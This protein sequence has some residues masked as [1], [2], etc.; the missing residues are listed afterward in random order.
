MLVAE[1]RASGPLVLVREKPILFSGP[2]VKALLTGAK[3]QTRRLLKPQPVRT[4]PNAKTVESVGHDPLDIV[5][6]IGWRWQK[7]K[8]WSAYAADEAGPGAFA[9]ALA[10]FSPYGVT[11]DRL[12]VRETWSRM[13]LDVYPCPGCWYRSDFTDFEDPSRGNLMHD[14]G[15]SGNDGNCW[16]CEERR[17]GKFKWKPAIH[18]RRALSRITLKVTSVRVERLQAITEEDALA[19]GLRPVPGAGGALYPSKLAARA[20]STARGEFQKLWDSLN[21]RRAPWASNPWVWVL[22]FRRLQ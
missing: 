5:R 9:N 10:N 15:C 7:S 4:L 22:S 1:V 17:H 14:Q 2:M 16:A 18:M 3:T 21:G 13:G 12:W 20:S 11:G 6:A 8:S 19:E